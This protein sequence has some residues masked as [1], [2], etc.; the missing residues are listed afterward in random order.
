MPPRINTVC[1]P[2]E[3]VMVVT[4][5]LPASAESYQV[6]VSAT[7]EH[8]ESDVCDECLHGTWELDITSDYYY[9]YTLVGNVIALLPTYGLD[10]SGGYTWLD[11]VSGQMLISFSED[12]VASGTQS[13][14]T[15]VVNGIDY[16]HPDRTISMVSTFNG[17]GTA[18]YTLQESPEEEKWIFFS[19]GVF[20]I[21]NQVYFMERPLQAIPTGGS[22]TSI[23]LSSPVRYECSE[24][25]LLYTTMPDIG[26]LIFHRVPGDSTP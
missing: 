2:T 23:F 11:S 3:Y 22:N 26:T 1:D 14:Y 8:Q 20:D 13:D 25:T 19:N 24:D 7:G 4:S 16:D 17:G 15:W 6:T 21:I 9:M 10:T 18:N 5:A 12:N